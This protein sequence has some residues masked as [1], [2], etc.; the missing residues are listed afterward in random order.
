MSSDESNSKSGNILFYI[1][2][3]TLVAGM[4]IA[5]I[6]LVYSVFTN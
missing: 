1:F 3:G 6:Y 2:S 4:I 5:I